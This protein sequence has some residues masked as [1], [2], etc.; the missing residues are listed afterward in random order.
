MPFGPYVVFAPTNDAFAA[1]PPNELQ[2][3]LDH[4]DALRD[5]LFYHLADHRIYASQIQNFGVVRML[6]E[7]DIVTF[8]NGTGVL[9]NGD[10]LVSNRHIRW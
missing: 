10:A 6:N 7:Q 5:V 8:I 1:L 3:L 2:Y 9:I 4:P